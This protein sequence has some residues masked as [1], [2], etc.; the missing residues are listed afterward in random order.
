MPTAFRFHA[1]IHIRSRRAPF[2][3]ETAASLVAGTTATTI[4]W[5]PGV[6]HDGGPFRD[7]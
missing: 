6:G 7:A 4:D 5:G 2:L 1:A 3:A